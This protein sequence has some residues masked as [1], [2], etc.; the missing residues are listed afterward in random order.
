MKEREWSKK[1]ERPIT[2]CTKK[3]VEKENTTNRLPKKYICRDDS[4][5]LRFL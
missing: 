4:Q 5:V 2:K 3:N 1:K